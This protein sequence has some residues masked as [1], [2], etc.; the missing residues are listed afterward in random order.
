M[1]LM[2]DPAMSET[3]WFVKMFDCWFDCLNVGSMSEGKQKLKK[4]LYSYRTASDTRYDVSIIIIIV[5]KVKIMLACPHYTVLIVAWD[6]LSGLLEGMEWFRQRKKR[7]HWKEGKSHALPK[8]RDHWWSTNARYV[9]ICKLA[10]NIIIHYTYYTSLLPSKGIH[11]NG[12][13]SAW[14]WGTFYTEWA[15]HSRP[16]GVFLWPPAATWWWSR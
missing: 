8:Q 2:G 5:Y 4:D 10:Y 9:M 12:V 3:I 7:H 16:S 15:I 1:E 13:L 6:R 14:R 11:L